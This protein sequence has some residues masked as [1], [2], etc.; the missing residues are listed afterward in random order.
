MVALY[1]EG[2]L[3]E[4]VPEG[5]VMSRLTALGKTVETAG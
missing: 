1:V 4:T 3:V 5:E 2:R